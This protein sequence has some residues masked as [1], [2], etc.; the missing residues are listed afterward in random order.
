MIEVN[1]CSAESFLKEIRFMT[2]LDHPH[3]V[4]LYGVCTRPD[5]EMFIVTELMEHGDLRHFLLNDAGENVHLP[6]LM[7]FAV[8]VRSLC[9]SCCSSS[10]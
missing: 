5:C 10:L 8:Q 9:N 6:D 2:A 4:K 7:R 1:L 3:V